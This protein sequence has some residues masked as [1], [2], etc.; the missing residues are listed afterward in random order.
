MEQLQ[1][2]TWGCKNQRAKP[3]FVANLCIGSSADVRG[4]TMR[5]FR[6][7]TRSDCDTSIRV[8]N[9]QIGAPRP[10]NATETLRFILLLFLSARGAHRARSCPTSAPPIRV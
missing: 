2:T 10:L 3:R 8:A 5:Y 4:K 1:D 9:S 6:R 7:P